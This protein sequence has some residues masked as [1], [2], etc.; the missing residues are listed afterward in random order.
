MESSDPLDRFSQRAIGELADGLGAEAL[1]PFSGPPWL[2]FQAWASR[3]EQVAPTPLG[4]LMHAEHGL[5]HGYR[6]ALVFAHALAGLP[7]RPPWRSPCLEC[8]ETPCLSACPVDAFDGTGFAPGACAEQLARDAEPC[9][10][11]GCLARAACPVAPAAH[12][13]RAQRRFHM[14]AFQRSVERTRGNR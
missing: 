6:G 7:Q 9:L 4:L 1:F 10:D 12:Y 5:W 3:A 14:Q 2:P 8:A 13:P 11:A